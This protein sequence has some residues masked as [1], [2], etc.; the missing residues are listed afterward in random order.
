V[1]AGESLR[2]SRAAQERAATTTLSANGTC[3]GQVPANH[4]LNSAE[5]AD[6]FALVT[7]RV[8]EN[9]LGCVVTEVVYHSTGKVGQDSILL[10]LVRHN[11]SIR[12]T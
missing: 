12:L 8:S 10:K 5:D 1:G 6:L 7:L 4:A 2:D 3:F 11:R 9:I